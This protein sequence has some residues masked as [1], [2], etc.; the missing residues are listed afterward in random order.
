M[1]LLTS[2]LHFGLLDFGILHFGLVDFGLLHFGDV[3]LQ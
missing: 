1:T 3:V 2:S